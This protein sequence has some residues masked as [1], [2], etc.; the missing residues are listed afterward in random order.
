MNAIL[1]QWARLSPEERALLRAELADDAAWPSGRSSETSWAGEVTRRWQAYE[2][3]ELTAVSGQEA[4]ASV[5]SLL[6]ELKR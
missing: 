5:R 2:R 4:M 6:A 1:K 3:G